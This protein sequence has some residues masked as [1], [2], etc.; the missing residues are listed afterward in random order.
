[1]SSP[2]LSIMSSPN[3]QSTVKTGKDNNLEILH[4]PLY[5]YLAQLVDFIVDHNFC[6][7]YLLLNFYISNFIQND[8]LSFI[9]Y[10]AKSGIYIGVEI[11]SEELFKLGL[12]QHI[13]YFL[14]QKLNDLE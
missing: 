12:F 5:Y 9:K 2:F 3:V 8:I 11:R 1:M 4:L 6:I 14:L 10:G 7:N 13:T